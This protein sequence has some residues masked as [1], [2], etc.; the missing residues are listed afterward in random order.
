EIYKHTLNVP[1]PY[2]DGMAEKWIASH[3]PVF[4]AGKGTTLAITLTRTNTLIGAIGLGVDTSHGRQSRVRTRHGKRWH[5]ARRTA[6][7]RSF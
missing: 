7:R 5:G 2:S 1:H 6:S 4:Y 3:G